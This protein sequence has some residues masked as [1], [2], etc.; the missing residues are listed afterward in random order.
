M[1]PYYFILDL[2]S[3]FMT[4]PSAVM[5]T[6]EARKGQ[7]FLLAFSFFLNVFH[8]ILLTRGISGGPSFLRLVL[9]S[10]LLPCLP[11]AFSE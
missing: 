10:F 7:F 9:V 2:F 1:L 8:S 5:W 11:L 4:S 3:L 6:V